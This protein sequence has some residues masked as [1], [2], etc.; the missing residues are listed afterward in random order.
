MRSSLVIPLAA[1]LALALATAGAPARAVTDLERLEQLE[2]EVALLKRKMEVQQEDSAQKASTAAVV[3]AGSDGFFVKSPDSKFI[4][5]MRGYAQAD[6]RFLTDSDSSGADTFL[7]RRA[8]PI[9]EGTVFDWVDFRIMPDFANSQLVLFD[10]YANLRY[11]PKA[12]LQIGKFKP[13]VG[14]ERLQ[15]ATAT[16]FA[17]RGFPTYLVPNRDVGAQLWG[18]LGE[19]TF[20][21]QIAA[22]NGVRDSGNN[23]AGDVDTDDG[24]DIV[25]RFF[26]HPLRPLGNEWFDNLGVG[27]AASYGHEN[28]QSPASFRTPVASSNFF[29]YRGASAAF[30][31][32]TNDGERIRLSPQ[33]YWYAGPFG[34][35]AEYV[36]S[37]TDMR[38][39]PLPA[40]GGDSRRETLRNTAWQVEASWALTGENAS[41][42]GL[43]PSSNF[44]PREGTWGAFEL[45]ARYGEIDFDD[46]SFDGG[47]ASFA[48]PAVAVT[49]AQGWTVGANWYLNR[50]L[51]FMVDFDRTT[52]DGGASG[53]G[54]T[55]N[56]PTEE[57]IFTRVQFNW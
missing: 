7:I 10:A 11:F 5:R 57:T 49:K 43:I 31:A 17:E 8:R 28:E 24:K 56:R 42:K 21:Y 39:D 2:Q 14:L 12:Q 4:L 18:E 48:D 9:F 38:R 26:V 41:Y 1:G 27:F 35:L 55:G 13:P 50:W 53:V 34:L 33:M 15:S 51:K 25:G 54:N 36:S 32:V 37:Q 47:A 20:Q 16:M 3:G 23:Q 29:Q 22:F 44:N 6:G 45:A 46:D 52:F 19:G 40:A 30:A